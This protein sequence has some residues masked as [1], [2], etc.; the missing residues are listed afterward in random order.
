MAWYLRISGENLNIA[1]LKSEL[2]LVVASEFHKGEPYLESKP[3]GKKRRKS[4]ISIE[5]SPTYFNNFKQHI[6]ETINFLEEN[7][8]SLKKLE[9]IEIIDHKGLDFGIGLRLNKNDIVVQVEVYPLRL[10]PL[11]S[12][13]GFD[14]ETTIYS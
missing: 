14:I 4:G 5:T 2:G 12:F 9:S 8:G 7:S 1:Q 6:K 10:I 3:F 11:C 13:L